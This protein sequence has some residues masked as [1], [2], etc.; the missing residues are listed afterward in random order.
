MIKPAFFFTL[1]INPH[2]GLL[3]EED[4]SCPVTEYYKDGVEDRYQGPSAVMTLL[5]QEMN[6]D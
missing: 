2:P 6:N 1:I 5:S 3:P 4:F